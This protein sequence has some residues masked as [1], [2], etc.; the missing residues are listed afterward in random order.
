MNNIIEILERNKKHY[1]IEED[2]NTLLYFI[3]SILLEANISN[4]TILTD[5]KCYCGEYKKGDIMENCDGGCM[6]PGA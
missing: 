4:K 3:N 2:S 6:Y 5:D 1:K